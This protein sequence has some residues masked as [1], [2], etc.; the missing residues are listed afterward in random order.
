MDKHTDLDNDGLISAV[1]K[2]KLLRGAWSS[3]PDAASK[4]LFFFL[5]HKLFPYLWPFFFFFC[6]FF[7]NFVLSI[8]ALKI[9]TV[10]TH[11]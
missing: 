7:A 10:K 11:L 3:S 8:L 5:N 6:C 9:S 2:F 1:V 4:F